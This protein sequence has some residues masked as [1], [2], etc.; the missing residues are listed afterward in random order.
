VDDA[1]PENV[2]EVFLDQ[3]QHQD[4]AVMPVDQREARR[5]LAQHMGHAL[6]RIAPAE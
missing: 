2:G 3:G 6:G 1:D 5:D 4:I